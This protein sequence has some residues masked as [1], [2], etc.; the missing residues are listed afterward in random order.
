MNKILIAGLADPLG[1]LYAVARD[2]GDY[3]PVFFQ[4][5]CER[6]LGSNESLHDL[7]IR[8]NRG[9]YDLRKEPPCQP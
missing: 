6:V 9:G 3:F 4:A 5:N 2:G 1:T 8:L 7:I